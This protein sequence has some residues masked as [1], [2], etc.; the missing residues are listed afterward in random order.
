MS[1]P[2]RLSSQQ[3]TRK[4]IVPELGVSPP[5]VLASAVARTSREA[6][7]SEPGVRASRRALEAVVRGRCRAGSPQR[8]QSAGPYW[9]GGVRGGEGAHGPRPRPRRVLGSGPER[10]LAALPHVMR[11]L[12]LRIF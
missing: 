12:A 4:G 2:S 5:L 9:G 3:K 7:G 6:A 11:S 10:T 8:P 1:H